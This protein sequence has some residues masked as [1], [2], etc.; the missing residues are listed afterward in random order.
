M[1]TSA[2]RLGAIRQKDREIL[3]GERSVATAAAVPQL[4][5]GYGLPCAQC[6]TYYAADQTVCPVCGAMER[7]SPNAASPVAA[8]NEP[9]TG[10][11]GDD[12]VLEAERERFLRKFKSQLYAQQAMDATLEGQVRQTN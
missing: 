1:K 7:V 9:A 2:K 11:C 3:R 4:R 8:V 5:R 10:Y 6:R 12:Q